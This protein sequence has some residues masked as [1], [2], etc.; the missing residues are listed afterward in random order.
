MSI[1]GE[2]SH[3]HLSVL[4]Y[5]WSNFFLELASLPGSGSTL[6]ALDGVGILLLSCDTILG[7]SLFSAVAHGK[8]VGNF[9]EAIVLHRIDELA[10][11][12]GGVL[13]CN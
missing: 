10:M 5:H 1:D 3:T 8:L 9:P 2:L 7:S 11:T 6:V 12:K 4:N 13:A